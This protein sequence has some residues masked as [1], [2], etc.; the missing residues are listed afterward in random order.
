MKLK[1]ISTR[2]F[3]WMIFNLQMK[4][5]SREEMAAYQCE[6]DRILKLID[7]VVRDIT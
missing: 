2:K 6:R 4:K 5:R 1:V 3:L 7:H